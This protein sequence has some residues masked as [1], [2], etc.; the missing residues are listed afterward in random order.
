MMEEG[1][2]PSNT[3]YIGYLEDTEF[4]QLTKE[5][6]NLNLYS[7]RAVFKSVDLANVGWEWP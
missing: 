7:N 3:K 1:P 2:R 4:V 5:P 6:T